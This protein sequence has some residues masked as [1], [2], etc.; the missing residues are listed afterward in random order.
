MSINVNSTTA[1]VTSAARLRRGSRIDFHGGLKGLAE[2][3]LLSSGTCSARD[4]SEL[5]RAYS[6]SAFIP[7]RPWRQPSSEELA[8]LGFSRSSASLAWR[9][10]VDVAVVRLPDD[11]IHSFT[12]M[13]E[14]HGIREAA[15]RKTYQ[16]IASHAR[17]SENTASI[18]EHLASLCR[19][20]MKQLYFRIA[21]PDRFT[22]T[23][24]EFRGD[25]RFVGLHLD[26][27]DCL[28]LRHRNR[29]RNRM[30]INFSRE[31]RYCLFINLALIEMFAS[32][33][34]RDPEDIYT[35]FRGLRMGARFMSSWPEY[36]VVRLQINPGE[37]YILPTDNL[38]HDASTEGNRCTDVTLTYL[39]LFVPR[40]LEAES[41]PEKANSRLQHEASPN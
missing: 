21:D 10:S 31:P 12:G 2:R 40:G 27:W 36:P 9:P 8:Q 22:L 26:N 5:A 33:G 35:D 37:A 39:G 16:S 34:L 30:C 7:S 41:M 1:C 11:L 14:Q 28:P 3:V 17:W 29:S 23:K 13:L 6:D 15:D 32:I 20:P 24:N 19:E 18:S 4:D 38:I 25:E